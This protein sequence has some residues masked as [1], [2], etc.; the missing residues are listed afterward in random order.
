[1]LFNSSLIGSSG[2][3]VNKKRS[4]ID[5]DFWTCGKSQR[6]SRTSSSRSH[7]SSAS[8]TTTMISV[9]R[10]LISSSGRYIRLSNCSLSIFSEILGSLSSVFRTIGIR[11]GMVIINC[12][13]RVGKRLFALPRSFS[14]FLKKK[15]APSSPFSFRRCATVLEIVDFPVPAIPFSQNMH[16]PCGDIAHFSISLSS[17]VRVPRRH[18]SCWFS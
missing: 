8:I 4:H 14:P 15:L 18:S 3:L 5:F 13:M 11:S 7:S 6:M 12:S 9:E 17:L 10:C 16:F 2:L 1:M